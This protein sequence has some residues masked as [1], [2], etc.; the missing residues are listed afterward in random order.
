MADAAPSFGPPALLTEAHDASHFDSGEPVLEILAAEVV[1][2]MRRN[3]S[4][5][6]PALLLERMAI[7]PERQGAG[8]GRALISEVVRRAQHS[9]AAA[10]LIIVHAPDRARGVA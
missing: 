7:D 2:S 1:G 4:P 8:L 9:D 5:Q 3:M 6:I 10:R